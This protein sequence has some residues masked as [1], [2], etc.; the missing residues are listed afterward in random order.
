MLTNS[1]K[2]RKRTVVLKLD[3][4]GQ[5]TSDYGKG[6]TETCLVSKQ[7]LFFRDSLFKELVK[8]K[9]VLCGACKTFFFL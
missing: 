2:S 9:I 4:L 6:L 7:L 3:M 5:C 8:M 1:L